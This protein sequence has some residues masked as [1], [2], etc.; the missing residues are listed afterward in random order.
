M[1]VLKQMVTIAHGTIIDGGIKVAVDALSMAV[2]PPDRPFASAGEPRAVVEDARG[3]SLPSNLA[4]AVVSVSGAMLPLARWPRVLP[5]P[6]ASM[7]RGYP[8]TSSGPTP[9]HC[10]PLK[11]C[12]N[13]PVGGQK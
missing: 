10:Y 5:L 9:A 6:V 3:A 8:S 11:S 1:K 13:C 12:S 4:G 7:P 2:C